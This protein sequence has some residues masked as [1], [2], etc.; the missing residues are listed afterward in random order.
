[1][2]ISISFS[3]S[4]LSLFSV[5]E[6]E[7]LQS[8]WLPVRKLSFSETLH[9]VCCLMPASTLLFSVPC[10]LQAQPVYI[11]SPS[12]PKPI[13]LNLLC[14]CG[15]RHLWNWTGTLSLSALNKTYCTSETRCCEIK[16][17][18]LRFATLALVIHNAGKM[19]LVLPNV[20]KEH[21]NVEFIWSFHT[22]HSVYRWWTNYMVRYLLCTEVAFHCHN[23]F[24]WK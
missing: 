17:G 14:C 12:L 23:D 20:T 1:M 18:G 7:P 15:G 6:R 21:W 24:T 8:V 4:F 11:F 13:E 5:Q 10:T 3:C 16:E 22:I 2:H 9:W 19:W